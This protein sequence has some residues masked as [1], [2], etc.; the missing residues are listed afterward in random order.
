MAW[1]LADRRVELLFGRPRG[2]IVTFFDPYKLVATIDALAAAIVGLYPGLVRLIV[3]VRPWWQFPDYP[4]TIER[5]KAPFNRG[6]QLTTYQ[7][8]AGCRGYGNR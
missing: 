1:T 7:P 2:G 5:P 4:T 3:E 6:H 8:E